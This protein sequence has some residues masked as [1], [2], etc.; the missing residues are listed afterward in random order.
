MSNKAKE[1]EKELEDLLIKHK[2]LF[3]DDWIH[4]FNLQF[5]WKNDL[6]KFDGTIKIISEAGYAKR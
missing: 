5:Y 1:F 2:E 6:V 3:Y 4:D